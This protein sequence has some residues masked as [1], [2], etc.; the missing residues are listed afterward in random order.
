MRYLTGVS[1]AALCIASTAFASEPSTDE[2][3][4]TA[5][6]R[7]LPLSEVAG[8]VDVIELGSQPGG[9]DRAEEITRLVTGLQAAVANGSQ[10]AYQIRG[11][12]AVDHQA[13][14]PGAAAV[15][16]DGVLLA[17]N[18]QTG[19]LLYD[20]ARVEVLKGP[21]G[22]LYGRN[23]SSGSINFVTNRPGTDAPSSLRLRAGSY[24]LLDV[25]GAF[26]T[27]LAEDLAARLAFRGRL[28]G[29]VLDNVASGGFP[30]G[31]DR[32]AGETE[33]FG[34]RLSVLREGDRS[35]ALLRLHYEAQKGTNPA[36]LN[37][38]LDLG[39]HEISVGNDGLQPRDNDFY[40]A[41]LETTWTSGGWD[42]T[43]L[44]AFEGYAQNYGFDF[45]GTPAPFGIPSLNANLRYNRDYWQASQE[46]RGV[47]ELERGSLLIGL[48]ASTD[49]FQQDYL[50]W[51]GRLDEAT[52]LGSCTYVG[53]PG[54]VGPTPAS[55]SP[56]RS[57]LTTI[58]QQRS[59][60]ALF[61]SLQHDLTDRLALTLGGRLTAEDIDGEGFGI[62]LFEDGTRAFNDRDG[63]G[64]AVGSNSIE[65]T[66][67]TGDA[68]LRYAISL[69]TNV[70]ASVASGF[71]SGGFNGEVA[72]NAGHYA[73]E[74]L[75]GAETV[76]AY[77]LGLRSRVTDRLRGSIAAFI[78]DYDDP[79]ARIF[80]PF[81]QPDGT[82][83]IS[84]SLSNLDA[85]GVR[86]LEIEAE[87]QPTDRLDLRASVTLLDTEI[88]QPF[89]GSS[90]A[91]LFDGNPLPF[92]SEVSAT[93]SGRWLLP[94]AGDRFSIAAD[95][96]YRSDYQLDAEGLDERK[97]EGFTTVNAAFEAAVTDDLTFSIWGRNLSDEDYAVSG[98][99]FIGTN[100]FR[101][102][103]RT[104]GMDL[105][106]VF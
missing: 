57:L 25:A 55:P 48:A 6:K 49:D 17:T 71:K 9:L 59:T 60:G 80:V 4:V 68:A 75:F 87:A 93:L 13:L 38:A 18:V 15:Y 51:C 89:D 104:V 27:S 83:I 20:M 32:A 11:I 16:R 26:E 103:P 21:Q 86:G 7:P 62:H 14:T 24:D 28:Q 36:P 8:S 47:K 53:A 81:T 30:A 52:L 100:T 74:G 41:S 3:I 77:E 78:L 73:D 12:G 105:R 50:I 99:G 85:A 88:Y 66:R 63:L 54:R 29:P 82:T 76:I 95:A 44:T 45:D 46:L 98:Y 19:F 34:M 37:S 35:T 84:N 70:Y 40:G 65:E 39:D 1:A 10:I 23:A 43:S 91:A 90:N 102:A 22:T 94:F 33:D 96:K 69:R 97:Q 101:S 58:E 92:A 79:Q 61:A 56:V 31:S 42:M 67:F 106:L 64:D 2:I 5:T 72:N